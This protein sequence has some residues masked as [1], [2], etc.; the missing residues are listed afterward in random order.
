[1]IQQMP[2]NKKVYEDFKSFL[3]YVY[4]ENF[5]KKISKIYFI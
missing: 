4:L 1:M 3:S 2:I 5:K